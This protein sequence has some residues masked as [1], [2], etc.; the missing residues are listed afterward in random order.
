MNS[1]IQPKEYQITKSKILVKEAKNRKAIKIIFNKYRD[2][3]FIIITQRDK[4]GSFIEVVREEAE[5]DVKLLS[6]AT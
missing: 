3:F 5:I 4:F 1:D 6:G 2:C